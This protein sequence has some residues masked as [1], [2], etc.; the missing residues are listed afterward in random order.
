LRSRQQNEQQTA[1]FLAQKTHIAQPKIQMQQGS[2]T[3]LPTQ[4]CRRAAAAAQLAAGNFSLA[5][6]RCASLSDD[7]YTPSLALLASC[8]SRAEFVN[9]CQ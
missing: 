4:A 2:Q 1:R 8:F 3:S 9:I 6:V 7:W 5:P